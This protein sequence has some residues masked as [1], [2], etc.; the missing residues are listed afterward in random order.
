MYG[1]VCEGGGIGFQGEFICCIPRP[2]LQLLL[3]TTSSSMN[4]STH[5]YKSASDHMSWISAAPIQQCPFS[6][7][8]LDIVIA[9]RLRRGAPRGHEAWRPRFLLDGQEKPHEGSGW[10]QDGPKRAPRGPK[11]RPNL[12]ALI[13]RSMHRRAERLNL[14]ALTDR[15]RHRRAEHLICPRLRY[16]A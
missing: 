9:L 3:H 4:Y 8:K 7:G 11:R 5:V 14:P 12:P 15:S 16:S 10:P 6:R 2:S 1:N 13:D